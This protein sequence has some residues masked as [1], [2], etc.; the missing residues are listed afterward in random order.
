MTEFEGIVPALGRALD[1]RGYTELTQVQKAVL[2]LEPA[3]ADALVSA[4][5][6]SGKTVA[7]GLALAPS[8]L[9]G[10]ESFDRAAAP[11]GLAVA[12]TRELAL[13]VKRELE[14]LY[15]ETGAVIASCVGGM[16]IRTERRALER[17]AHIVVG[18]PGRLCDHI[19]RNALDMSD[20]RAVVLDEADEMLDLG[21]REDLEFILDAAP[22]ER[23][24]LMFSATVS[25]TIA[26]LAKNYQRDAVRITTAA[27]QKQHG[28]IEYRG[29]LAIPQEREN[30]IINVLRYYEARNALVFCNT[31]ATVN[32]LTARFNNRGFSVV[33][34]SGE[35][36]QSERTHAL[37]AMRD[38]RARVCVA[39]DVAAR[40]IDLPNLELVV[41]ADLP[42][43]SETL[44]HRSGRTGRAGRKGVSAL[45]VAPNGRRRAERLLRD[46][47][48][49][50][51]WT[52]PPSADEVLQRD[53]ERLMADPHLEDAI[54]DNET[55][56]V[57]ALLEKHGAE[58]IAAA[59]VRL[60]R[61][62]LSAPE[63]VTEVT[64]Q[65]GGGMRE[66]RAP[67]REEFDESVW[68]S[69]SVGRKQNAE[70]RWLI[71][72]LCRA[73]EIT[74]REIGAI[75]MQQDETFVQLDAACVGRFLAAIGPQA[76]LER[77][78]RV[79]QLDGAPELAARGNGPKPFAG[80]RRPA[81]KP[82]RKGGEWRDDAKPWA[83][84]D[85]KPGK[86]K[87][88]KPAG[89]KKKARKKPD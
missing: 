71:P 34:L 65:D 68:F 88:A 12:P 72:L 44:L 73:G 62:K 7:F 21:F 16:D 82:H 77:S 45:I 60:H 33:A 69:L 8:L 49:R 9:D 5:T 85:G 81:G 37:Q 58:Q 86:P 78:I 27:E 23:R 48:V 1:K 17:G 83:K 19:R 40:G 29:F 56:F 79:V 47:K 3:G 20:L 18:T 15:A 10:A 74:K 80:K 66:E 46:A 61:A 89:G 6:G 26:N 42:T 63:D 31:R 84:K 70:P 57:K 22:A 14:W 35:L 52:S 87:F 41:H 32:H 67:R 43:N 24:T 11:L 76:V 36:S 75:K 51:E 59:F 50:L 38:G 28:D 39:T 4:Q 2:E 55:D 13:Q 53:D 30:A 54:Q 64:V 25:R